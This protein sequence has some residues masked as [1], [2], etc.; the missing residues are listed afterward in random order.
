MKKSK[1]KLRILFTSVYII[2]L[3]LLFVSS[4][5]LD[6]NENIVRY[7]MYNTETFKFQELLS[8]GIT[9]LAI[10]VGAIITVATVLMSMCDK[11]VIKL[12]TKY[13]K[14]K[15]LTKNIKVCL[16]S[17]II[18]T[19]IFAFIYARLDFNIIIIRFSLLIISIYFLLIFIYKS[20][21][22]LKIIL[23][24]LNESF[25]NDNNIVYKPNIRI[26]KDKHS[27]K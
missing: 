22:L 23:S 2:V 12:I 18:S 11:R 26:N 6:F 15:L 16:L 13:G 17:G 1:S 20:Y 14:G 7:I 8:I 19:C 3:V 21:L 27:S 24:V 9:V 4:I 25:D 5:K 10:F